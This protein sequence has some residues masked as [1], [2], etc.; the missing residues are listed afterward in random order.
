M[1]KIA[2][3]L[4]KSPFIIIMSIFQFIHS[5]TMPNIEKLTND[6]NT[7]ANELEAIKKLAESE[8]TPKKTELKTQID[9]VQGELQNHLQSLQSKTDAQSANERA[10]TEHLLTN[11]QSANDKLLQLGAEVQSN[12]NTAPTGEEKKWFKQRWSDLWSDGKRKET[13]GKVYEWLQER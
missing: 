9:Q 12:T 10:K 4:T 2:H 3:F 8:R 6:T 13:A 1:Y 11:I 7:I 5:W